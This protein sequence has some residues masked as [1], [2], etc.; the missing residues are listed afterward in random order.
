MYIT[1]I[2]DD[3]DSFINYI[4]YEEED[5]FIIIKCLL[6]SI[7][8]SIHLL[9][10]ISLFIWKNLKPL[11]TYS[12]NGDMPISFTTSKNCYFLTQLWWQISFYYKIILNF[13]NDYN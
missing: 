9:C 2:I 4:K 10:L 5:F 8:S 13:I 3:F 11:S 12:D 1:K 6:L 7:R